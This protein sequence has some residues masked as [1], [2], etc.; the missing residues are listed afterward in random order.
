MAVMGA[1]GW[2]LWAQCIF[3]AGGSGAGVPTTGIWPTERGK[4]YPTEAACYGARDAE[5]RKR[6][7]WVP[8]EVRQTPTGLVTTYFCYRWCIEERLQQDEKGE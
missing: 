3:T 7:P 8:A 2:V 4:T 1:A 6:A 5:L